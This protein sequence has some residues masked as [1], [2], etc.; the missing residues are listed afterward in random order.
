MTEPTAGVA[1]TRQTL[2]A[3]RGL[4]VA[5]VALLAAG[6]G[7]VA[8]SFFIEGRA[9]GAGPAASYVPA[10]AAMYFELRAIPSDEQDGALRDFLAHFPLTGLDDD[11]PLA[12]QVADK[13][14]EALAGG[15][16]PFSY[17]DDVAPWWDG[18]MAVAVT[19]YPSMAD[20]MTGA[21][22]GFTVLLGVTDT[23]AAEDVS[24]RLRAEAGAQ[25]ATFASSEHRGAT[26]W[27]SSFGGADQLAYV[28]TADQLIL[29][30]TVA[31][32]ES[33]LDVRGGA[34]ESLARNPDAQRHASLL[35]DD[36]LAFGFVNL[37]TLI[38]QMEADLADMA[39][40][41]AGLYEA[42]LAGQPTTA[43]M[44]VTATPD[45]ISMTAA[46]GPPTG[47]FAVE[48]RD[49]GL[50]SSVPAGALY[51][52]DGGNVGQALSTF[53]EAGKAAASAMPD[54]SEQLAQVEAALGA[55]LEELVAWMGDAALAIGVDSGVP[56][57]GLV[58]TPTDADAAER[59]LSQLRTLAELA[60]FEGSVDVTVSDETVADTTVTTIELAGI[61][62]SGGF[63]M[64]MAPESGLALQYTLTDD[65]VLIGLGDGFVERSLLLED[66]ASLAND[67]RFR[68][69]V[70]SVGG[71]TNAGMAW[72]D[73]AGTREAIE[74][75]VAAM[76]PDG[77]AGYESDVQP[78]LLPFDYAVSVARLEG[79]SFVQDAAIVVR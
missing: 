68:A 19:D 38:E 52:A 67:E 15:D 66:G 37:E 39:P 7:I 70:E 33:A 41:M 42:L 29:G 63:G 8:G 65:R 48:N 49:R 51:F 79:E 74:G 20:S 46:S 17:A 45:G 69:A 32:V 16:V 60:A 56:Y 14:D 10:D 54:G 28:L 71:F 75:L 72:L 6:I 30:S 76:A 4:A 78:W 55:D 34:G 43:L 73:L 47:A 21:M 61:D 9:A 25:G 40:E 1:T 64:P 18:R 12:D 59:R 44:A 31:D 5:L 77:M 27:S 58:I 23:T 50:A 57:G 11:R 26:V 53:I 13:L 62:M 24:D 35:P 3:S 2:P 36:Y 22:P